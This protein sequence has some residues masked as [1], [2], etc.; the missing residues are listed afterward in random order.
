MA[1]AAERPHLLGHRLDV[2]PPGRLL[3]VGVAVGRSAGAGQ[4]DVAAGPGQLHGDRAPDRAHP[5]GARHD[6]HLVG[7]SCQLVRHGET[8]AT[9]PVATI[10]VVTDWKF[11]DV[12]EAIAAAVPDRP[13]QIQGDRVVTWGEL[14]AHASALAAD[15]V[16][17]GLGT[18]GQGGL[19]PLQ[20]PRVPGGRRRR[21]QGPLRAGQHELPL[22]TGRDPLPVRQRRRRGRRLP[23]HVHRAARGHPGPPAQG[24]AVVRRRRRGRRR[25]RTGPCRTRPSCRRAPRSPTAPTAAATTSCSS[26]PAAPPA[27][28]RA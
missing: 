25:A 26:T 24:Q 15:L 19:L 9:R 18:P 10:A 14:D 8:V 13:C 6:G 5:A 17:A 27:C 3:V 16:A 2:A 21:V 20:L 22:R 7:Q 1:R 12:Y 28:R 4:H 23:R 11:A